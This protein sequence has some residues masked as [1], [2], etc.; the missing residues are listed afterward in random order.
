MVVEGQIG[1]F[2][3]KKG[4]YN[5]LVIKTLYENGC[6]SAWKIARKIADLQ[7]KPKSNWYHVTQK[8]NSVLTR[9]NGTLERLL[10]KEFI[11]KTKEGYCLT[12]FKGFCSALTLYTDL[13]EPA[14]DWL[15]KTWEKFPEL[16]EAF[17]IILR[18]HPE[19]RV[20]EYKSA[21]RVTMDLLNQG[22]NLDTVSNRQFNR[23]FTDQNNER[24]LQEMKEKKENEEKWK[25]NPELQA[26]I[27]KFYN[28]IRGIL[29][30]ELKQLDREF[31]SLAV[32]TRSGKEGVKP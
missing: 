25:P 6:L 29:S 9:R 14:I 18:L 8:V 11:E 31:E 22:W 30:D 1:I 17:D 12:T 7:G 15:A 13:K 27:Q 28:R 4:K 26:A 10:D 24:I 2:Q 5:T 20:E 32:H 19:A 3:G 21:L 16:K 23:I